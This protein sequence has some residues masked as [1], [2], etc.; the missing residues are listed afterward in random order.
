MSSIK[1]LIF[2][3]GTMLIVMR[4]QNSS[5]ASLFDGLDG[6]IKSK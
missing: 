1:V 4:F 5:A 6:R 3:L 2:L